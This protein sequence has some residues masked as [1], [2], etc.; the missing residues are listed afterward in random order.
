MDS[1]GNCNSE[2]D[3]WLHNLSSFQ[4]CIRQLHLNRL[5]LEAKKHWDA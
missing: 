4:G 3:G 5:T 1:M 2:F